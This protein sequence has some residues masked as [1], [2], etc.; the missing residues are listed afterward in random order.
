MGGDVTLSRFC[1]VM[2][3]GLVSA[4]AFAGQ[5]VW[6]PT[7]GPP[8]E[9]TVQLSVSTRDPG[10]VLAATDTGIYLST[11]GG[12]RW[13]LAQPVGH[14]IGAA[15]SPDS[16][17]RA[18]A[19]V[20]QPG[21][22]VSALTSLDGGASWEPVGGGVP[23]PRSGGDG[24][25]VHPRER[26][27]LA[28]MMG[29]DVWTS[30][31]GGATW[32]VA[33]APPD[34]LTL[35][36]V[37]ALRGPPATLLLGTASG[38]RPAVVLRSTD[39]G[40]SWRQPLAPP[41]C[42]SATLPGAEDDS[43]AWLVCDD[44]GV[45]RS[46]DLGVSWRLAGRVPLVAGSEPVWIARPQPGGPVL[47][48]QMIPA[49]EFRQSLW[50]SPDEGVSWIKQPG[51]PP[52]AVAL[53][54]MVESRGR[55]LAGTWHGPYASADGGLTWD[56][57]GPAGM[58][59]VVQDAVDAQ[60]WLAAGEGVV[61]RSTDGGNSWTPLIAPFGSVNEAL[62][63][64]GTRGGCIVDDSESTW[65]S[66]DAGT[67]WQSAEHPACGSLLV[68]GAASGD[69]PLAVAAGYSGCTG[70]WTLELTRAASRR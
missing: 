19:V 25:L 20:W 26:G 38:T 53:S 36:T 21:S 58:R 65:W 11:D 12:A 31:D 70:V 45:W 28:I 42:A 46:H 37:M 66:L 32:S 54:G 7:G 22:S 16:P 6:Q 59:E 51:F 4:T 24:L 55:L 17:D 64:P 10:R 47:V 18:W 69:P 44:G 39:W 30:R 68:R 52:G 48:M 35:A 40:R 5:Q 56:E 23:A 3:A 14:L 1:M 9:R 50:R 15:F 41:G 60:L 33:W 29:Q 63:V 62:A 67:S 13:G 61:A 49:D 27:W 2:A 43:G 34:R 8:G 57:V